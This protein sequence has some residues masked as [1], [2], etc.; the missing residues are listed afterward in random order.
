MIICVCRQDRRDQ[1]EVH[2]TDGRFRPRQLPQYLHVRCPITERSVQAVH[3]GGHAHSRGGGHQSTGRVGRQSRRHNSPPHLLHHSIP[4]A[5]HRLSPDEAAG[6]AQDSEAPGDLLL[7]LPLWY[8]RS[9]H[10][11]RDRPCGPQAQGARGVRR[12]QLHAS[13]EYRPGI[14]SLEQCGHVDDIWRR[15]IRS[16]RWAA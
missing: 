6:P 7:R 9:S 2:S 5:T 1:E 10:C 3:R 11:L 4:E 8:A 13:P 14:Q 12:T 15:C 16:C